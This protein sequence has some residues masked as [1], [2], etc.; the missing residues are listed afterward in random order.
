[1]RPRVSLHRGAGRSHANQENLTTQ[2]R[3]KVAKPKLMIIVG[4]VR[5][6][7][8]GLPIAEWVKQV[9]LA[10][11]RSLRYRLRRSRDRAAPYGRAKP[12][13]HA[14]VH[15]AHT[16][17]WANRVAAADAFIFVFPE[18]NHIW[19]E[20][21]HSLAIIKLISLSGWVITY[22][23]GDMI[24]PLTWI[25]FWSFQVVLSVHLEFVCGWSL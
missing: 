1:M 13:A 14:A 23:S 18:Y 24:L 5:E 2:E 7:R 16:I 4:S 25:P 21:Q 10:C 19:E 22:K 20:P 17:E 9:A 8:V 6:G 3:S 15:A 12:P 11:R